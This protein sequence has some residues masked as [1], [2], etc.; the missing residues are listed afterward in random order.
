MTGLAPLFQAMIKYLSIRRT[1]KSSFKALT[2]NKVST[3]EATIC[4]SCVLPATLREMTLCRG[5]IPCKIACSPPSCIERA[6]QSPIAG[7]SPEATNVCLSLPDSSPHVSPKSVITL[8][9]LPKSPTIL[10][11]TSRLSSVSFHF[12]SHFELQFSFQPYCCM[13]VI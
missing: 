1:L 5:N 7:K 11:G 9:L 10:P 8:Y 2:R 3:F 12:S 6:T 4:S 13:L